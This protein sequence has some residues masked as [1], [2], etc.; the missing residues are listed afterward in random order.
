MWERQIFCKLRKREILP[1]VYGV[2]LQ[3]NNVNDQ[4]LGILKNA[5]MRRLIFPVSH[6]ELDTTIKQRFNGRSKCYARGLN[7]FA[8]DHDG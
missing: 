2:P 5:K 8:S 4:V 7:K 6:L 1:T 3:I